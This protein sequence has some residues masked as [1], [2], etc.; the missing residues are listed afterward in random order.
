M[1]WNFHHPFDRMTAFFNSAKLE[2]MTTQCT[3]K[4]NNRITR[5]SGSKITSLL[6][7]AVL[8]QLPIH[9]EVMPGKYSIHQLICF[10][11]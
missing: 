5:L 10:P 6:R 9:G 1:T 7:R 3:I 2:F 4:E 11:P 8:L